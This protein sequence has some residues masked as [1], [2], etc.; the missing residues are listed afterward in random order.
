MKKLLLGLLISNFALAGYIVPNIARNGIQQNA[1]PLGTAWTKREGAF[2]FSVYEN[3]ATNSTEV[4]VFANYYGEKFKAELDTDTKGSDTAYGLNLG[5]EME[6]SA[7]GLQLYDGGESASDSIYNF[8]YGVKH[9][10]GVY[11][12]YGIINE[13]NEEGLTDNTYYGGVALYNNFDA[14]K[15]SVFEAVLQYNAGDN[16]GSNVVNKNTTFITSWDEINNDWYYGLGLSYIMTEN[17][18]NNTDGSGALLSAQA[19]K[20]FGSS[21]FVGAAFIYMDYEVKSTSTSNYELSLTQLTARYLLT[22]SSQ[23]I[24]AYTHVEL[25]LSSLSSLLGDGVVEGDSTIINYNFFF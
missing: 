7:F 24:V 15:K 4:D 9:S 10:G 12:G 21:F 18:V 23:I 20:R 5:Y 2:A 14:D 8:A 16:D 17:N 11:T 3:E 25:D 6:G 19:E 1:G 22:P 13:E